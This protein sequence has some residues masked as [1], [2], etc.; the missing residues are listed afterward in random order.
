MFAKRRSPRVSRRIQ[1]MRH[2]AWAPIVT[3]LRNLLTRSARFRR[4]VR[5]LHREANI[6]LASFDSRL[7]PT[8]YP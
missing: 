8:E 4:E 2:E 3:E 7:P 5:Q 1:Q 6:I